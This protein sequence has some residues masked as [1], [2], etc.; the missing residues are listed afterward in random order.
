MDLMLK[1]LQRIECNP[2]N[3]LN[4]ILSITYSSFTSLLR[5]KEYKFVTI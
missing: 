2:N 1:G 5:A 4:S 3:E